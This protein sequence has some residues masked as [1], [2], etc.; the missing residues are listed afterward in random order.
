[1]K[2][3]RPKGALGA[4]G[5]AAACVR[6]VPGTAWVVDGRTNRVVVTV[7]GTCPR[8]GSPGP[9]RSRAP[10]P[11]C[12]SP[13]RHPH[14]HLPHPHPCPAPPRPRTPAPPHPRTLA[15]PRAGCR[16]S[17][18]PRGPDGRVFAQVGGAR[19]GVVHM[20]GNGGM[21]G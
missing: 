10:A 8:P 4:V 20:F 17:G 5:R 2:A 13:T 18:I 9:S 16:W 12:R 1:M 14:S 7:E 11:V 6:D 19:T 21:V 3:A 15:L